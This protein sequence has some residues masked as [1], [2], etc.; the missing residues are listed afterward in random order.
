[1]AVLSS[2]LFS[3]V[4]LR[5]FALWF[6]G[7]T[8]VYLLAADWWTGRQ[9]S[10]AAL[11]V[12]LAGLLLHSLHVPSVMQRRFGVPRLA[13]GRPAHWMPLSLALAAAVVGGSALAADW[14]EPRMD[15][16]FDMPAV[17]STWSW[18]GWDGFPAVVPAA[19]TVSSGY[20]GDDGRLGNP[21][22]PDH[23]P[24]FLAVTSR[25]GRYWRGEAKLVYTGNGWEKGGDSVSDPP[26]GGTAGGPANAV[27]PSSQASDGPSAEWH[28]VY[29]LDDS[30][31]RMER[32]P[33]F[34]SGEP[35]DVVL[36]GGPSAA[37]DRPAWETEAGT[38]D[39][40]LVRP[41]ASAAGFFVRH[42]SGGR[43]ADD[44]RL[45]NI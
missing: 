29:W 15:G 11:R 33:L 5:R 35:E 37:A 8:L 10:R 20:G 22:Q 2:L 31:R 17:F 34:A 40:H 39:V 3:T 43:P 41:P 1:W 25:G 24:A 44:R 6:T 16:A 18:S 7:A 21:L 19:V 45:A 28:L 13:G 14:A 30:L 32:W 27:P 12:A 36:F 38:G 4:V 23:A 9:A 42:A 26:A